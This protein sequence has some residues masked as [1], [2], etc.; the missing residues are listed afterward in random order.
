MSIKRYIAHCSDY[1]TFLELA[2]GRVI[3]FVFEG[4]DA[5]TKKRFADV[6]DPLIQSAIEQSKSFGVYVTKSHEFDAIEDPKDHV[7]IPG[8][9]STEVEA[10]ASEVKTF[11]STNEAKAW[12]NE[13]HGVTYNKLLNK[14]QTTNEYANL[15]YQLIIETLKKS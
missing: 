9:Q 14:E 13:N 15:G 1:T 10:N 3:K 8:K 4:K 12:L 5:L 6:A 7:V 2:D 11:T